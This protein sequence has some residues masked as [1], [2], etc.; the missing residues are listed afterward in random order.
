MR[1]LITL[2]ILTFIFQ[3]GFTQQKKPVRNRFGSDD[4]HFDFRNI[5]VLVYYSNPAALAKIKA[6]EKSGEYGKAYQALSDYVQSFGIQNF[7]RDSDMIWR[8]GQLAE[9]IG[10]LEKAK[11]IYRLALRHH[12]NDINR[13]LKYY[14][15]EQHYDSLNKNTEESY[16]PIEYYYQLV[17]YRK[18]VDTLLPPVGVELNMGTGINSD[19][20]DYGPTLDMHDNLI[21]TSKRNMGKKQ[22]GFKSF[23]N[24]DIFFAKK[25]EGAYW[26]EAKLMEG[27]NTEYNEGSAQVSKDGK[28]LFFVR[29]DSPDGYGS[30]DIYVADMMIAEKNGQPDTTWGNVRNL[31][32]NVNS[33]AWD[34]QPSLSH[35]GDTLYFASDRITGFGL[36]DIY[37][38][39][40]LPNGGWSR[41][42][43]MGPVIN[44][45][46][47]DVSPFYHPVYNVLYFSSQGQRPN[48]GRFDI[49]RSLKKH[50]SW[51]E[52][53][54]IGPLVNGTGD[55]YYFAIDRNSKYL[56][57][58]RNDSTTTSREDLDLFSFP[59]P[60]EAQPTATTIFNVTVKD[61][62]T[63][64]AFTGIVSVIDLTERIEI[65]P[66]NLRPDGSAEFKLIPGHDYM[67]IIT[68]EDFFRIERTF[69]L[70]GDTYIEVVTPSI[71]LKKWVFKSLEFKRNSWDILSGMKA[72]LNKLVNFMIDH[73]QFKIKISGHTDLQ[74]NA[75]ENLKLSQKRADSIKQYLVKT[76]RNKI[77]NKRIETIGYGSSRPIIP[78]ESTE[79]DRQINRRVEFE[80]LKVEQ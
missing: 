44:T 26:D 9:K 72:D 46:Q 49:Y 58:A 80:V 78:V 75:D 13:I 4:L 6:Y 42:Q 32:Q 33:P 53:Y 19:K 3:A 35:S 71:S 36:S 40:K 22:M 25:M 16:V 57:Y 17:E 43:N 38:C 45:R 18:L 55:E 21:L 5:N 39:Y 62:V 67:A 8:W 66:R 27:I 54:N 61:S 1:K 14:D 7:Y 76:S 37:F 64:N 63:G 73:P 34:S 12:R 50:R 77:D 59:L 48:F 79:Q 51:D 47:N 68:G 2:L 60:M 70:D 15:I 41:A 74:G 28:Q 31:G 29:C 23:P 24:E 52:P 30:C 11:A 69:K 56:F 20:P 10:E 65:M